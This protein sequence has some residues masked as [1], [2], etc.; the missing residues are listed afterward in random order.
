M[1]RLT[2][3]GPF[4]PFCE[5][6]R[7]PADPPAPPCPVGGI[8]DDRMP[9]VF[10][11]HTNLVSPARLEVDPEQFAD[12]EATDH[13]NFRCC[14]AAVGRDRHSLPVSQCPGDRLLDAH[15]RLG[16]VAPRERSVGAMHLS[17]SNGATESAV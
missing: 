16:Q 12:L 6:P 8:A 9:N 15:G 5:R 17:R 3:R 10:Q 14:C 2:W 11:M 13:L 4:D 1:Q 7:R